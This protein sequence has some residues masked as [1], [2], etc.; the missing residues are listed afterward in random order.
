M[1][2]SQIVSI[3]EKIIEMFYHDFDEKDPFKILISTILSQRTRDENTLVASQNL[4]SKYPN[5]ESLA[6]AKPEE[7][8]D[9]IKPS[10]M[11]RQKAERIIEVS[12]IILEKY[13]GKVPSD[14]DE[15]LKLPGVGRKTANIVLFQGFSIPAIAVDTHVH[16][17]S[18]RLGFVKT[19][20]PEQTEE[21]LSKV[22]PKR[23]WGPINVAMVNFGRNICLPRNP[24]CE[25]C[26]FSKECKYHNSAVD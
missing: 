22:L 12:K 26:P 4:F 1:T 6:K 2:R 16:R 20:T 19:K 3:A 15:L 17:I 7:I 5:V 11:Y 23:L 14:L 25:K 9:L 24:R 13:N 21:E 18:N 8:Y 10:G